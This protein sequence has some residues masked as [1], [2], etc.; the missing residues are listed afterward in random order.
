MS[1]NETRTVKDTEPLYLAVIPA[2]GGSKRLPGKNIALLNEKPL[3]AYT[4]EA[5]KQANRLLRTVVSTDDLEIAAIARQWGAEVPFL[6]PPSIATDASPMLGVIEH[7]LHHLEQAGDVVN[8]VV[9]LQPASPFRT[10]RHIDEALELFERTGADTVTSVCNARHHPYYSWTMQGGE[11]IP[12]FSLEHQAMT[13]Q[14]LPPA[15]FENGAIFVIRRAVIAR[16]TLY[17]GK[18]VPYLM[19][20]RSSIDIDTHDDMLFAGYLL[21][22]R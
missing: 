6:R 22:R 1:T 11:L 10:S 15:F 4:I 19:D 5:A 17:G 18:T 8:T 16:G 9:L 3:I 14:E 21:Q 20:Y 7:V 13:R 2:R 12:F